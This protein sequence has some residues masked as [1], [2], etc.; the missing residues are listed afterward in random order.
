[1]NRSV[2]AVYELS[3]EDVAVQRIEL[4]LHLHGEAA[5]GVLKLLRCT[6]AANITIT[7]AVSPPGPQQ[8]SSDTP[9]AQHAYAMLARVIPA[10][11]DNL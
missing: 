9:K 8:Q 4:A 1:M 5:N 7:T 3:L 6:W 2:A 11:I 10:E